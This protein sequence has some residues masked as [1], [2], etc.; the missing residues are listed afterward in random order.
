MRCV[1]R[2]DSARLCTSSTITASTVS[3]VFAACSEVSMRYSDSGVVIRTSGGV[4]TRR[5]RSL[6]VLSPVRMPVVI[7]TSGSSAR[8][9]SSGTSRFLWMSL[10][11]ARRGE[12]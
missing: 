8:I 4:R 9:P 1:P 12:M 2:F 11:S 6:C 7:A 10:P 5:V 3:R